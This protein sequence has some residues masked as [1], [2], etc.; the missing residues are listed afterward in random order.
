MTAEGMDEIQYIAPFSAN[1]NFLAQTDFIL[2]RL[3]LG[4]SPKANTMHVKQE[5]FCN[6]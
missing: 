1:H 4:H 3:T 2:K 6:F 5:V